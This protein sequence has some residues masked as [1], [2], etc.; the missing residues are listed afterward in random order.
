MF[1][2]ES[3][4]VSAYLLLL[5]LRRRGAVASTVRPCRRSLLMARGGEMVARGG[6]VADAVVSHASSDERV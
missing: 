6:G 4:R 5:K 1:G 3:V 2:R